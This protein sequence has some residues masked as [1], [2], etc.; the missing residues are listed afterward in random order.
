MSIAEI[1]CDWKLQDAI[2]SALSK[3]LH[4]E[5]DA[6]GGTTIQYFVY[7]L[8]WGKT[9]QRGCFTDANGNDIKLET[10]GDLYDY[11]TDNL[12]INDIK[13]LCEKCGNN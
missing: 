1:F 3:E 12:T 10:A 9:W 2:L 8:N 6:Y 11:L 7:E 5:A 4:D 13:E